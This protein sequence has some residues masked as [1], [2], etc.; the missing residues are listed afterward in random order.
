MTK[1]SLCLALLAAAARAQS[2]DTTLFRAVLLPA[3]EVPAINNGGRAV[4]DI[5]ASVMRD[6]G[7]QIVSGSLDVLLRT[8]LVAA[9]TATGL[10]FHNAAAGQTAPASKGERL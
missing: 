4:A 6:S 5:Q 8:T 1:V 10:N 7:G 3:N 9:N 2:A